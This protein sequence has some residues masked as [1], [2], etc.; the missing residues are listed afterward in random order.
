MDGGSLSGIQAII[1]Q[2]VAA[3]DTRKLLPM[4]K[5]AKSDGINARENPMSI[6][7]NVSKMQCGTRF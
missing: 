1:L 4:S 5:A 3:E 2:L 6:T 7:S